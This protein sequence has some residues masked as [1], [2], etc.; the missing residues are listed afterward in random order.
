MSLDDIGCTE[1]IEETG[2]TFSEN[3]L[4]KARY[5]HQKYN[6]DCF[7][8]DSGLEVEALNKAPGVYSARYAGPQ[9]SDN[10]NNQK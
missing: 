6:L 3:T 8:D 5:I 10:D 2:S 7:A 1:D 4:I 9:K